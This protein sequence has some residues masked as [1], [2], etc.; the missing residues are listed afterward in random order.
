MPG[1]NRRCVSSRSSYFIGWGREA[2]SEGYKY[3]LFP[4]TSYHTARL[5]MDLP[6]NSA[7]FS[8]LSTDK[9]VVFDWSAVSSST[10]HSELDILRIWTIC[11]SYFVVSQ[12]V[13]SSIDF[14]P[15]NVQSQIPYTLLTDTPMGVFPTQIPHDATQGVVQDPY[16]LVQHF[17]HH[18]YIQPRTTVASFD[19]SVRGFTLRSSSTLPY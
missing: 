19:N 7:N 12:G 2:S 8:Q 16:P 9:T 14:T 3:F 18:S 5:V 13:P 17:P 15:E 11:L 6:P 1:C 4:L 10:V